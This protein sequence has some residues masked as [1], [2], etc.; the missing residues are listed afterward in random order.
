MRRLKLVLILAALAA[1]LAAQGQAPAQP[2]GG[3]NGAPGLPPAFRPIETTV[4]GAL[5]FVGDSPAIKAEGGTVLLSMPNFYKYAYTEALKAGM[6]VKAT[7]FLLEPQAAAD[8][9]DKSAKAAQASQSVLIAKE[10][11][12]GDR[13]FIIV[14]GGPEGGGCGPQSPRG[15]QPPKAPTPDGEDQ[16]NRK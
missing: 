15:D 5:A 8:K 12:I 16:P 3:E 6:T 11:V 10:V 14:G 9:G 1:A 7:G 4:S 13:T 2:K